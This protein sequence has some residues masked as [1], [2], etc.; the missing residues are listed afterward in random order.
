VTSVT[1]EWYAS[2]QRN[3]SKTVKYE[4]NVKDVKYVKYVVCTCASVLER[5]SKK[6][7]SHLQCLVA[8]HRRGT[9]ARLCSARLDYS[10][11]WSLPQGQKHHPQPSSLEREW[12]KSNDTSFPAN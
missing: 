12:D 10:H 5:K 8:L 11:L 6:P 7:C 3:M 4:E 1:N 9:Y 2:K